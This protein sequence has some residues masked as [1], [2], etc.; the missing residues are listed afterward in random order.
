M[1]LFQK[2]IN[3]GVLPETGSANR[4]FI[5]ITN[6]VN[7]LFICA[8]SIPLTI[9]ITILTDD[10]AKSYGR[11]ILL[12]L[13]S[14]ISLFLNASR[15]YS[16]A[17]IITSVTP[18]FSLIIFPIFIS[19]F[20][21]AGMFLWIPYAFMV[22]GIIPFLIFSLEKEKIFLFPIVGLYITFILAFD[23]FLIKHFH[24]LPD[25]DF[26]KKYYVYYLLAKIIITA[27]LYSSFTFFKYILQKSQQDLLRLSTELDK[28]NQ[29]LSVLNAT[30]EKKVA[31]RTEKLT[32][33]NDRIKNL[34]YT[35]AHEIRAYIARIIG[36]ISL[37]KHDIPPHEKEFCDTK[38]EENI[39]DLEKI[40]Q[41]LSKELIEER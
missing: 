40:T 29:S 26:I 38:I 18:A 2:I 30:L 28:Q 23:E 27:F 25:L 9:A 41:K 12:L 33:Q 4:H 21:H 15:H 37:S 19:N 5:R 16:L 22:L 35:N 3:L 13:F 11:C 10:G 34:A 6:M 36:L 31:E 32:L 14:I 39:S 24:S 7:L 1:H 17:K 20:I 8:V